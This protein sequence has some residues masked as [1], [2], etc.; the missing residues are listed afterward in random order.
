MDGG[1]WRMYFP[2]FLRKSVQDR[3]MKFL[4]AGGG[5]ECGDV[6]GC[7]KGGPE[8]PPPMAASPSLLAAAFLSW[9][10]AEGRGNP[11]ACLFV[12]LLI[13]TDPSS[14]TL[15]VLVGA[16]IVT[17]VIVVVVLQW[18]E[19]KAFLSVVL[20]FFYPG[21]IWKALYIVYFTSKLSLEVG[22]V[23]TCVS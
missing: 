19:N 21:I 11:V 9:R 14:G 12:V 3:E 7:Q 10:M 20:F 16:L 1:M 6:P 13:V 8:A 5:T 22:M 4:S 2:H 15:R 18:W 17:E 23:V